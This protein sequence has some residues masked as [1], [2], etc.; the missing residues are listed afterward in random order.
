[1]HKYVALIDSNRWDTINGLWTVIKNDMYIPDI[2]YLLA[3][4]NKEEIEDDLIDDF[5]AI[6]N[7]YDINSEVET[8]ILNNGLEDLEEIVGDEGSKAALDITGG[9]K[10]LAARVLANIPTSSFDHIF[11]LSIDEDID[12]R[13]PLPT[14]DM[15]K[16]EMEDLKNQSREVR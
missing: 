8:H 3:E 9:T 1:M 6:L 13:R 16:I 11:C 15:R 5:K 12:P 14:I 2:I 7:E 10:H 4:K